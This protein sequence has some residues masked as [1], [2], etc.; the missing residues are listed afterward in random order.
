MNCGLYR[1]S[2]NNFVQGKASGPAGKHEQWHYEPEPRLTAMHSSRNSDENRCNER[3]MNE[4][5]SRSRRCRDLEDDSSA[6][7]TDVT[8][9]RY[10]LFRN[11]KFS[12]SWLS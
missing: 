7:Q 10:G 2:L 3:M 8:T 6:D 1:K 4:L 9:Y 12:E 5:D 11:N